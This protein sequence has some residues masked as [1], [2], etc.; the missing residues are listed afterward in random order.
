MSSLCDYSIRMPF[1]WRQINKKSVGVKGGEDWGKLVPQITS[2]REELQAHRWWKLGAFFVTWNR[3]SIPD[4]MTGQDRGPQAITW[5]GNSASRG[6]GV[7]DGDETWLI[8]GCGV[9][10]MAVDCLT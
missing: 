4:A 7:G 9:T 6:H 1:P 5:G 3:I 10:E 2:G 8:K